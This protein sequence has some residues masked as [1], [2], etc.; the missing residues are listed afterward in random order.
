[1]SFFQPFSVALY[2]RPPGSLTN[3]PKRG[4][5]REAVLRQVIKSRKRGT[6][7][8]ELADRLPGMNSDQ[9]AKARLEL[10][11][12]G[13]IMDSSARRKTVFG[14]DAIV[15]RAS[16]YGNESWKASGRK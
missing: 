12:G 6:T 9:I 16:D 13:F 4:S 14:D 10:L 11:E 2:D 3:M 7:S 1:M 5:R 15:W 8:E